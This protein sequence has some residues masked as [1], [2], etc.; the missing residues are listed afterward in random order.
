[1]ILAFWKELIHQDG[2]ICVELEETFDLA[3]KLAQAWGIYHKEQYPPFVTDIIEYANEEDRKVYGGSCKHVFKNDAIG[4]LEKL[5]EQPIT[6]KPIV[7]INDI[8]EIPSGDPKIYDDPQVVENYLIRLWE[9]DEIKL[10]YTADFTIKTDNYLVILTWNKRTSNKINDLLPKSKKYKII[11]NLNEY[12]KK[13]I[14]DFIKNLQET[15]RN[16]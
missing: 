4:F 3:A 16:V 5:S 2:V 10:R 15:K 1:M 9:N 6:P 12:K 13:F 11:G 14:D 7:I 8:T